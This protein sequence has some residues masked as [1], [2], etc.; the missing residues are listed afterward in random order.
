VQWTSQG[1]W[2]N[3]NGHAGVG[4]YSWGAG[5]VTYVMMVNLENTV[6]FWWKDTNTNLSSTTGHPINEWV[7]SESPFSLVTPSSTDTPSAASIAINNVQP[8]TSLGYTNIFYAQDGATDNVVGY[9]ITWNAENTTISGA[10]FTVD[11]KPGLPGTHLSVTAEPS[12]SGGNNLYVFYQTGGSD[13]TE[14][15]RDIVSGQWTDYVLPVPN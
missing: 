12:S 10:P 1:T 8:S 3:K 4:C 15:T 7:N 13:I 5:T 14:F 11:G 6:E 2:P 9:N